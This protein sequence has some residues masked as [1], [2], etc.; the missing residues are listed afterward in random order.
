MNNFLQLRD[1]EISLFV[2][3]R[4]DAVREQ[5]ASRLA[6][7]QFMG[8]VAELFFPKLADAVTVLLGGEVREPD[9]E[10][11]TIKEGGWA[12]DTPPAGPGD[13]DEFIR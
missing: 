9:S 2:A 4:Q 12:G 11:L 1:E 3:E 5:V 7:Y 6:T 8:D 13:R 10:Y